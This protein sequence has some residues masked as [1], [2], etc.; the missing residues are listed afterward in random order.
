MAKR[1]IHYSLPLYLE[2]GKR[3]KKKNYLNLNQYR[4]WPF[5]QSNSLKVQMKKV[6]KEACPEFRFE[7][8]TLDYTLY[9]M[10]RRL[11]DV[12]N[13]CSVIDKFQCDALVE[14]GY[15]P[16]DN[17]TFLKDIGYHFGGVDKEN[18][19]CEVTI[20]EV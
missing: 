20:R 18:P 19:R 17:Y 10:D 8:F 14:L 2:T 12:S 15:V 5:H 16:D 7:N 13:V 1:V 9:L 4:N 3:K 11:R 6:V